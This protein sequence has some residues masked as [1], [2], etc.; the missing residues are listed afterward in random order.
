MHEQI[1]GLLTMLNSN[2]T[3]NQR[4]I[5]DHFNMSQ[6]YIVLLSLLLLLWNTFFFHF[7]SFHFNLFIHG[8]LYFSH[9]SSGGGALSRLVYLLRELL[10][11]QSMLYIFINIYIYIYIYTV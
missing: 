8:S 6:F 11:N 4:P 1:T 2:P 7:I 5:N 10:L 3:T 9:L